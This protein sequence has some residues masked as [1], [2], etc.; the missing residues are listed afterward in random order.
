[1]KHIKECTKIKDLISD[2][3]CNNTVKMS[4]FYFIVFLYLN[5]FRMST[6]SSI[7]NL[8]YKE[9]MNSVSINSVSEFIVYY[10]KYFCLS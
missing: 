10:N 8:G 7:I 1:M 2:F 6:I 9:S 4:N 3:I 5:G